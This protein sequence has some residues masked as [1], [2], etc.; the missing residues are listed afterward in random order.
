MVRSPTRQD[1]S[2]TT[3]PS[4]AFWLE[5]LQTSMQDTPWKVL[6]YQSMHIQLSTNI[7]NDFRRG[8]SDDKFACTCHL[9]IHI[10]KCMDVVQKQMHIY[11][12]RLIYIYTHYHMYVSSFNVYICT[13]MLFSNIQY[14]HL[15][16]NTQARK[17]YTSLYMYFLKKKVETLIQIGPVTRLK[18][19][20]SHQPFG[21]CLPGDS[22]HGQKRGSDG[23]ELMVV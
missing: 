21:T 5:P 6:V 14:I 7:I 1:V 19:Q 12:H 22:R 4:G 8:I 2:S 10:N 13:C 11:L 3:E 20:E 16:N 9:N 17:I 18:P 15:N 23:Q